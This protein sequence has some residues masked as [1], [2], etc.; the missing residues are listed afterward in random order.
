MGIFS[1]FYSR[2][3][4]RRALQNGSLLMLL[5]W[6]PL[7][8]PGWAATG[9]LLLEQQW[10]Q[11]LNRRPVTP[12]MTFPYQ[13]CFEQAARQ[14]QLPLA[15]L[16]AVARGESDF[17]ATAKSSANALGLMQIQW[18]GTARHLNITERTKLLDPC[19]N[20]EAGA[21]YLKELLGRFDQNLHLALAAYN[22]GPGTITRRQHNLP[23]GAVW[24]SGYI[25]RH[26]N[27]VLGQQPTSAPDYRTE[28]SHTRDYTR[29]Y[30]AEKKLP[31]VK[32]RET[33]RA[34]AFIRTLEQQLPEVRLDWFEL[35]LGYVQVV[36]L[37]KE[38]RELTRSRR[39]L[40]DYGF[41]FQLPEVKR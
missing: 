36:L 9:P 3:C 32:F 40:Y 13:A 2:W 27:Y 41:R 14:H 7:A 35:G 4:Q 37:Y 21:R 38:N 29:N 17:N 19:T 22:Y 1:L 30:S 5:V 28:S 11:F 39:Q 20:V 23:E 12:A 10:Q 31:L 18:P 15:L 25:Y 34:T 26:L 24:Y 16:L 33:Y 8:Q 6:L